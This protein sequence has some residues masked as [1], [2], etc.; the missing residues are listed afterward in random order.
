M[1]LFEIRRA[2]FGS[3][4]CSAIYLGLPNNR[5]FNVGL[6]S[7]V[8][9][10]WESESVYNVS[11]FLYLENSSFPRPPSFTR[12]PSGIVAFT[13][14]GSVWTVLLPLEFL[15]SLSYSPSTISFV[16]AALDLKM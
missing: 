2:N 9:E 11:E 16:Q 5:I 13:N 4:L 14:F 3:F 10:L 6:I 12:L 1:T 15:L 8:S 7:I